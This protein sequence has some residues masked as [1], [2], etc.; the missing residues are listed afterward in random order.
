MTEI[1]TFI[2]DVQLYNK[3]PKECHKIFIASKAKVYEKYNGLFE[4]FDKLR[5]ETIKLCVESVKKKI[6]DCTIQS[7]INDSGE[8]AC[9]YQYM[10]D[11][12]KTTSVLIDEDEVI[13]LRQNQIDGIDAACK[14]NFCSGI[15]SQATGTGKSVMA[16]VIIGKYHEKYRN[17][18]VWWFSER[19]DI[20]EKLFFM[21]REN[22]L[23]ND[24]NKWK[25]W[26]NNN[27][28]DMDEFKVIEYITNK[29]P[30]WTNEINNYVGEKPLFIVI[31]RAYLTSKSK[32]KGL[33][34]RYQE[35]TKNTPKFIIHDE[36]H[37]AM[38]PETFNFLLHA[39]HQWKSSIQGL[40]ATPYRKGNVYTKIN[41][42]LDLPEGQEIKSSN[43]QEKLL[44]IFHKES[45]TNELNILSWFNLMEAIEEN[46]ILEPIFH[47]FS[48][49]NCNTHD[50]DDKEINYIMTALNTVMK[51]CKWKKCI[52]WCRV[53]N[54]A[55]SWFDIFNREKSK[56]K[57]LRKIKAYKDHSECSRRKEELYTGQCGS[58]ACACLC[59][60][61]AYDAFYPEPNGILFCASMHREGSDIPYLSTCTFLDKVSD[62]GDL[63][64]IQ[65]V[66]RVLRTTEDKYFG[67]VLDGCDIE[68]GNKIKKIADK[69]LKYY[70][71]LFEI[72]KSEYVLATDVEVN[73]N[74]L[75][76]Y[77]RMRS[78]LKIE[79]DEK[80]VYIKLNNNKKI[81]VDVGA[82]NFKSVE[83]KKVILHF[84]K[85][86]K[87]E[88][89]FNDNEDYILFRDRCRDA[90]IN[91]KHDYLQRREECDLY[92]V[93]TN[94]QKIF[95]DPKERW[96]KYFVNWYEFLNID[97]SKYLQSKHEW[98]SFCKKHDITSG[99][100]KDAY[101]KYNNLPSMPEELY[102][103]FSNIENE[104]NEIITKREHH[105]KIKN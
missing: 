88:M 6:S 101:H 98:F 62:R 5:V 8:Y 55:N 48:V 29:N 24:T 79:P 85:A 47:W 39:K 44:E 32:K 21:K 100:Y 77:E 28:I 72:S 82:I 97:T 33:K 57:Y 68:S 7:F 10:Y 76:L 104:L 63:P 1:D 46:I 64:F 3:L 91:D 75:E 11:Q 80:K 70:V 19:I 38:A 66:G 12:L 94:E 96:D 36:C 50:F 37:S 14:N 42:P 59:G 78:S 40:S 30:N 41:I 49:L 92:Y 84:E 67:H 103:P 56:Y 54:T 81:T 17:N 51:E 58:A 18:S 23:V 43:N 61:A 34:Y 26:K 16:L 4:L 73:K 60:S 102:T 35:I 2:S 71:V 69:L 25:T 15:H 87:V 22:I 65:C 86:L 90:A 89:M 9:L 74:K 31:N 105:R 20:P 95:I 93:D 53:I 45:D 13:I 27:I 83:F 52:A 99:E